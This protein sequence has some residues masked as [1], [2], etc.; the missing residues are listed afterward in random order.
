VTNE[1][2]HDA[3]NPDLARQAGLAR[4]DNGRWYGARQGSAGTGDYCNGHIVV[5]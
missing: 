3:S 1:S 2:E 5:I 4:Q